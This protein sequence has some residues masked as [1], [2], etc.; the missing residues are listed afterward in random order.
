MSN[1]LVRKALSLLLAMMLLAG[2]VPQ[3]GMP[4]FA[5]EAKHAGEAVAQT[6]PGSE[7]A[8]GLTKESAQSLAQSAKTPIVTSAEQSGEQMPAH[9]SE[10]ASGDYTYAVL[11][12]GT[13]EITGYTG[14][15]AEV[16]IPSK[17]NGYRVTGI[18]EE[19]FYGLEFLLSVTIPEGVTYIVMSAFNSCLSLVNVS[20]PDSLT[21]IGPAAFAGCESLASVAVPDGVTAIDQYAFAECHALS[22]VSL[23]E[24]LQSIGYGAFYNTSI[25]D[26]AIPDSVTEIGGLA[27][28]WSKLMSVSISKNVKSIATHPFMGCT[29]LKSIDVD[30]KNP[31]YTS[32]GGA[33][34]NKARTVLLGYPGGG[35]GHYVVPN[36]VTKICYGAFMACKSLTS[37]VMP[38]SVT[39]LEGEAFADC[40]NLREVT[41]SKGLTSIADYT[42][43]GCFSLERAVIPDGV[44]T[45]GDSAFEECHSLKAVYLPDSVTGVAGDAF[46]SCERLEAIALPKSLTSIDVSL[47]ADCT[48]LKSVFIPKSVTHISDV[49]FSGCIG[50]T[51]V[52]YDG[53]QAQWDAIDKENSGQNSILQNVSIHCGHTHSETQRQAKA[54]TCSVPGEMETVCEVCGGILGVQAVPTVGHQW[55][56]WNVVTPATQEKEGL[57][58]RTCAVC[59]AREEKEIPR[60]VQVASADGAVI[61]GSWG[62][63]I[64]WEL[65]R[66]TGV[67]T[68]SGEGDMY[69]N[70]YMMIP[71]PWIYS[72]VLV[73]GS[74]LGIEA[75]SEIREVVVEEGVTSI[76][77]RAF[78][79]CERLERVTLPESLERI[80]TDAFLRCYAL[81]EIRLPQHGVSI[82]DGAFGDTPLV[83]GQWVDGA[84][85]LGN[86]LLRVQPDVSGVFT[87][88]EGTT[89]IAGDAFAGCTELEGVAIPESVTHI[90]ADAFSGCTS[91]TDVSL[92]Q[93]IVSIGEDA[94]ENTGFANTPENWQYDAYLVLDGCL[95]AGPESGDTMAV[96][97]DIRIVADGVFAQNPTAELFGLISDV[98][99]LGT[100]PFLGCTGLREIQIE[101]TLQRYYIADGALID[102]E[103]GE[104]LCYPAA[105]DRTSYTVPEGV[106]RIADGAFQNATALQE[107]VLPESLEQIGD[108][109]FYGCTSLRTVKMPASLESLG[110]LAFAGCTS[111]VSITLPEGLMSIGMRAFFECASLTQVVLP[112]GLQIIGDGT[113]LNCTSLAS[114]SFPEGLLSIEP[115]A[116][117]GTALQSV[118]LPDSVCKV[119]MAAFYN[120]AQLAQIGLPDT[121][122]SIGGQAF[123]GTAYS[124][125]QANWVN[126]VLYIGPYL[127]QVAGDL[128]GSLAVREGTKAIADGALLLC[129]GLTQVILPEG[130]VAMGDMALAGCTGLTELQFPSSLTKLGEGAFWSCF[131]LTDIQLPSGLTRIPVS[132]LNGCKS[133]I[134]LTLP[135]GILAIGESAFEG[136]SSLIGLTLPEGLLSIGQSAFEDCAGLTELT[137]PESLQ[138]IGSTAFAGTGVTQLTL[139]ANVRSLG[140]MGAEEFGL[141]AATAFAD[142]A[143]LEAI[144]VSP[145]NPYYSSVDGVLFNKAHTQLLCYPAGSTRASYTVPYGVTSLPVMAFYG[146]A[147]LT[148]V[149]LPE[150]ITA[151]SSAVFAYCPSLASVTLPA[152]LKSVGQM[153]FMETALKDVYYAGSEEQWAAIAIDAEGND[154]LLG[155][156]VHYN[157]IDEETHRHT[158]YPQQTKAPTCTE[159]GE[160]VYIC[161]CG[162]IEKTEVIPAKG[163]TAQTAETEPTCTEPGRRVTTCAV[164]GVVLEEAVTTSALGHSWG[165]WRVV[166]PATV[167]AEGLQERVCSRCGAREEA[168]LP[169]LPQTVE[170][171]ENGIVIS[172]P[173]GA[174]DSPVDMTVDT[175]TEGEAFEIVSNMEGSRQSCIYDITPVSAE[176]GEA[177]QPNAPVTVRIPLP[178]GY[179]T[180]HSYVYHVNEDGTLEDMNARYEDG[181]LVFETSHFSVYAVVE[182]VQPTLTLT[183]DGQAVEGDVAYVKL[184][185]V[186]MMY[187]NHSATL[188]F[189]FDQEVEVASVNWSYASWSVDSPEANI[190]SP[191]SAETVV[192]PNGKGIGARSTWVTLTVTDVDGNTYQQTVKVRFYKWDW[193]R[194]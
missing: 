161:A 65:N 181:C 156:T 37:V 84:Q 159:P 98:E 116:F 126:G 11:E 12:D 130:L 79:D 18:G 33:L 19:A 186:L 35:A 10:G 94:F 81:R 149:K 46:R 13:A 167:E 64:T 95:L 143:S 6:A 117:S 177:V 153:A 92:P 87:I 62:G 49:A 29:N 30:E 38:D 187:K 190:E 133:L 124:E 76:G 120:C 109:A 28:A 136:C 73:D 154:A 142:C 21:S 132:L 89:S 34:L 102:R 114:V 107:L 184:P 99:S 163:H 91:L 106:R 165:E 83:N 127:L 104:L 173:S 188:G 20:F 47:F 71:Q 176:S 172:A 193:Q 70:W 22:S 52:Y 158:F 105:S 191:T 137:L 194:K 7:K 129:Q 150:G 3:G 25:T 169:R 24:G 171:E 97:P 113:F 60:Q 192:R 182:M 66:A 155:A 51:D 112:E 175:V 115:M 174:F 56:K 68:I 31:Y 39:I 57:K 82:S 74:A 63:N 58:A 44:T 144:H 179:D 108:M 55:G 17:I 26:I 122:R 54:P 100:H 88:R 59:G 8:Y 43:S 36:G 118:A 162:E 189:A 16:A 145:A 121:I 160:L 14:S 80:E 134:S 23:P 151:L 123:D 77:Y 157:W 185:S 78:C 146:P 183:L 93:S 139:P 5:Q 148:A 85:Y 1:H 170:D 9:V 135:E 86:C 27:F 50:L 103:S 101:P 111:L 41:F 164:C 131:G 42:F 4:A 40:E 15:E 138:A 90:G 53:S 180:A 166:T 61:G 119:G 67:L 125:N 147:A 69:S 140:G 75:A 168:V 45:I 2:A 141:N 152:S 32:V 128:V 110:A 48:G 178:E 72:Q 96:P